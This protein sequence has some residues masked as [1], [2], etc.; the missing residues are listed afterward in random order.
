MPWT[1]ILKPWIGKVDLFAM[2]A[3]IRGEAPGLRSLRYLL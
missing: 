1:E 3:N 2:R